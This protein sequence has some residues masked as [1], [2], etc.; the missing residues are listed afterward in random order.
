ML[1][2]SFYTTEKSSFIFKWQELAPYTVKKGN[3]EGG[4]KR[5]REE[6]SI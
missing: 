5:A 1:F 6:Y 3:V 4:E 2:L